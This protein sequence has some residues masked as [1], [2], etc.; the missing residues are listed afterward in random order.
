VTKMNFHKYRPFQPI[1]L[2]DRISNDCMIFSHGGSFALLGQ[3]GTLATESVG[4]YVLGGGLNFITVNAPTGGQT[5][6]SL[7]SLS[8]QNGGIGFVRGTNLGTF[9][10]SNVAQ[11]LVNSPPTT[12]GGGGGP[13]TPTIDIVPFLYGATTATA[14]STATANSLVT[15][16]PVTG[17]RPLN[18][19]TEYLNTLPVPGG[20]VNVRL[21]GAATHS[22][23]TT[24]N[25]LVLGPGGSIA[26]AGST[27]TIQSGMLLNTNSG[28]T[29]QPNLDFVGNEAVI[30][31]A[32]PMTISGKI[33]G[34][35][36]LNKA[37][38]NN[39]TLSGA[40][41]YT[42]ETRVTGGAL[43]FAGD[44]IPGDPGPLGVDSSPIVLAPPNGFA[45]RLYGSAAGTTTFNRDLLVTGSPNGT[46]GFG[47]LGSGGQTV[48]MNGG[49]TLNNTLTLE[50]DPAALLILNG[51]I[52]GPGA[53]TDDFQSIQV[54]T[55]ANTF[56]G[57]TFI[58]D[59]I[60][61]LGH[62]RAL[63]D[64]TIT[65]ASTS[66][67]ATG[68]IQAVASTFGR[69]PIVIDNPIVLQADPTFS[70]SEQ[71]TINGAIDLGGVRTHNITNTADTEYAGGMTGG[72][73]IKAGAGRLII[74]GYSNYNG[75]TTI[76]TGEVMVR[77]V[78]PLGSPVAPT[79]VSSGAT[80]RLDFDA[81][82]VEPITLSGTGNDGLGALT[83]S[84][85]FTSTGT[86]TLAAS[87]LINVDSGSRLDVLHLDDFS[88]TLTK[89]GAG[90]LTVNRF[91]GGA[92][93]VNAGVV[94]I[95]S[96]GTNDSTSRIVAGSVSPGAALDMTNNAMVLDYTGPSPLATVTNLL[97]S[98]YAGGAWTGSG[99]N[100]STAAATIGVGIGIAE[101]SAIGSP[102]TFY[103]QPADATSLLLRYTLY[104]DADL[105][106]TVNIA[107][108]ARLGANF[109]LPGGWV[110]GDFN[111]SGTVNIADFALLASNFNLVLPTQTPARPTGDAAVPEPAA[112]GLLA[113]SSLMLRRRAR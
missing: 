47:N 108:F 43:I 109:N 84:G 68:A 24:I 33:F 89:S 55:A 70:G 62:S 78:K 21:V 73:L 103:G 85:E 5:R 74:S 100:S 39:A 102:P 64:E 20:P 54:L 17:I 79:I 96:G 107:D 44:V 13:G 75:V 28:A 36:G 9:G 23:S 66:P 34:S 59:G 101:A 60:Y 40:S 30:L 58:K 42:G 86:L 19:N 22:G 112:M 82:L 3:A 56:T 67:T 81:R 90:V 69:T 76:S 99:I 29:L 7:L 77:G 12:I 65:F 105:D 37:G 49:V 72:G 104:G 80:L 52:E 71:I 14:G 61:R 10:G 31:A 50:G 91:R 111:Y 87:A 1:N 63:G 88:A 98:G 32:Q 16:D 25:A 45:A 6:L 4:E 11:L 27:I 93:S 94:R 97:T 110:N 113:A 38:L 18:L 35:G 26:G 48:V 8:R 2:P 53:L 51:V 106:R 83:S 95:R 15:Y 41:T 92:V 57:G 46:V